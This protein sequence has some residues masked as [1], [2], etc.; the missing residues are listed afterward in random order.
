[1]LSEVNSIPLGGAWGNGSTIKNPLTLSKEIYEHN[2]PNCSPHKE[3][4]LYIPPHQKEDHTDFKPNMERHPKHYFLERNSC[5][6]KIIISNPNSETRWAE[7]E[8][9]GIYMY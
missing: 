9:K 7:C 8:N 3:K 5:S 2:P 6:V 4:A 1:M